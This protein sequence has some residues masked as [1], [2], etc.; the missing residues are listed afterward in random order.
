MMK[1]FEILRELPKYDTEETSEQNV[2][3]KMVW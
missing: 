1:K 2:V 3:G